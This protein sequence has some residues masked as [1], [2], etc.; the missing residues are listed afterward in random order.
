[1][2]KERLAAGKQQMLDL[3]GRS[4]RFSILKREVDT[5]REIYNGLLSRLKEIGVAGGVGIN[6]ISI[7]DKAQVPL[8]PYKPTS[9]RASR[10]A[11]PSASSS[12]C[13]WRGC[14]ST[15]TTRS[16]S[17]TTWSA[18]RALRCSAS[19]RR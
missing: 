13:S 18:R 16:A 11:W 12:A 5:N 8:Y 17:P 14:S 9:A 6:N 15:W 1:M 7:V 3:Q 10:W 4:M 19:S 2:L